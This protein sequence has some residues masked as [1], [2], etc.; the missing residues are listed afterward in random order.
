[1]KKNIYRTAAVVTGLSVD[2]RP[3]GFIYRIDLS[4]L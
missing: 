4:R 1:M 3:L 2:E